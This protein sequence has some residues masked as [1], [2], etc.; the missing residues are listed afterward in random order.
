MKKKTVYT[1]GL[2][3]SASFFNILLSLFKNLSICQ[4]ASECPMQRTM[5]GAVQ[6][7]DE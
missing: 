3:T 7:I 2:N 5:V 4:Q 1:Q 6:A